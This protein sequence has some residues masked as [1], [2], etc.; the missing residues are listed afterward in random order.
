MIGRVVSSPTLRKCAG[1][2]AE[3]S[4]L[5]ASF[6]GGFWFARGILWGSNGM[7]RLF[8]RRSVGFLA[9]MGS[10][11]NNDDAHDPSDGNSGINVTVIYR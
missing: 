3:N 11:G 4:R 9:T 7:L 5:R 2:A 10:L 1:A 6:V 8:D